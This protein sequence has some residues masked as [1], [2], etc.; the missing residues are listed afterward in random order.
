MGIQIG[1]A[2]INMSLFID[3]MIL[4][5]RDPKECLRKLLYQI[6]PFSKVAGYSLAH[7]NQQLS[8]IQM[9]SKRRKKSG[10]WYLSQYLKRKY[11][12]QL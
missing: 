2:E 11:P 12:G 7:K 4:Y 10:R 1:K 5:M 9:T 3:D 8:Y 6:N